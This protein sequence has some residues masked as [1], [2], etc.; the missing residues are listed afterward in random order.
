VGFLHILDAGH[1]ARAAATATRDR[2][3]HDRL[4]RAEGGEEGFRFGGRDGRARPG[5][6]GDA[7]LRSEGARLHLV[8]EE[9]EGGRFRPDEGEALLGAAAG[10]LRVLAEETVARVDGVA[11]AMSCS[12]SR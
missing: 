1:C 6:D 4:A 12:M 9:R 8:P 10:E 7:R 11:T 5:E 2:L 3:Q